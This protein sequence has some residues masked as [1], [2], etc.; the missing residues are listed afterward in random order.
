ME[1]INIRLYYGGHFVSKKKKTEY[2]RHPD[3]PANRYGLLLRLNVEE[4]CFF[5][6]VYWIKNDLGFEDVGEIWYRKKG[7]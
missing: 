6:F 3:V 7:M 2:V 4:V 5:E 1:P